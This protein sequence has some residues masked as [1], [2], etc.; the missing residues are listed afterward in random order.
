MKTQ[1]SKLK[2]I[3]AKTKVER[4]KG[5][6]NHIVIYILVNCVITGFKTVNHLDSWDSFMSE[7]L[8]I[9][10]LSVW[11]IWGIFLILHM[12]SFKFGQDW[13]ER[14]IDKLMKKELSKYND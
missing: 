12:V 11:I 3:R 6:Y 7:F 10:V 2:Y 5:L 14:K 9:N 13:E 8:S 1:D 4:L